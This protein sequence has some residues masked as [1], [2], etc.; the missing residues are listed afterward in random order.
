ML[1]HEKIVAGLLA[2][3]ATALLFAAANWISASLTGRV[4]DSPFMRQFQARAQP[5]AADSL[6]TLLLRDTAGRREA[7]ILKKSVDASYLVLDSLR[8]SLA[9]SHYRLA[10]TLDGAW[11]DAHKMLLL[12]LSQ[13][14]S[15]CTEGCSLGALR[16]EDVVAPSQGITAG[17]FLGRI[18]A[19]QSILAGCEQER[20]RQLVNSQ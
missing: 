5:S 20:L 2:V 7:V 3:G 1:F 15:V 6:Y 19:W 14:G 4:V 9:G 12:R 13:Q 18:L 10:D 8:Q 17:A 11:L 16:I